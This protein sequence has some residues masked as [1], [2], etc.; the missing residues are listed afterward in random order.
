MDWLADVLFGWVFDLLY[1]LQIGIC[2][3]VDFIVETFYKLSGLESVKVDGKETDL[4]S[5]FVQTP[6]IRTAFLGVFLVGVILLCVFVLIAII[7]SEYADAQHKKTKGQILMKAG[8][9]F[10]IFS[11]RDYRADRDKQ[12]AVQNR[13]SVRRGV[14]VRTTV[15]A[16]R[17][18]TDLHDGGVY[19]KAPV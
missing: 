5:H 7:L 8:Q 3:V 14:F 19:V 13:Y 15:S 2:V 17:R 9:S 10:I 16:Y 18:G 12:S 4:L 1:I 6:A 11:V